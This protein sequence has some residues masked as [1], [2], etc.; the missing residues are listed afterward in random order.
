LRPH[1]F[2]AT[3]LRWWTWFYVKQ[4]RSS[5]DIALPN[6]AQGEINDLEKN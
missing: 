5:D 1:A 6:L 2:L 3:T 4:R